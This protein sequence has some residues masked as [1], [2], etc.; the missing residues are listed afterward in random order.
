MNTILLVEDN[1][2]DVLLT[3]RA[4]EKSHV[5]NSVVVAE[6]GEQA[7][8]ILFGQGEYKDKPLIP[9]LILLDLK[10]PKVGGLEVLERLQQDAVLSL[11]PVIVL[12]TS[13]EE[14]D[15]VKSYKYGANSFIRKPVDFNQFAA[16]VKQ[17]ELYWM[18]LNE[19]PHNGN[20]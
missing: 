18:V 2:D 10:M 7:L 4:F 13:T 14:E 17:L 11:I 16:A 15:L 12:T 8:E 19:V 6:D 1:P 20:G 9:E 3:K 5:L